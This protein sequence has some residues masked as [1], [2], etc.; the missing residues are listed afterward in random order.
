MR[1]QPRGPG[2]DAPP[3]P[4]LIRHWVYYFLLYI[5]FAVMLPYVVKQTLSIWF[6]ASCGIAG[7]REDLC[8]GALAICGARVNLEFL[9]SHTVGQSVRALWN[10]RRVYRLS[11]CLSRV[12]SRKLSEISS[13][14]YEIRSPSKNMT[15]DLA[16]EVAKYPKISSFGS[17][18][19]LFRSVGDAACW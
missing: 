12:R 2:A 17:V 14:L 5:V 15:S 13:P 1:S 7:G 4:W 10:G 19:A 9:G 18:R 6:D 8:V 11:V 3:V 16:P